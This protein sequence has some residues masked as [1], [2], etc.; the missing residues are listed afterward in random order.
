M[1]N[2]GVEGK[3]RSFLPQNPG[4]ASNPSDHLVSGQLLDQIDA[5][6]PAEENEK[7]EYKKMTESNQSDLLS[8]FYSKNNS[9]VNYK[10]TQ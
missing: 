7:H 4:S 9:N 2:E 1:R 5:L 10:T 3:E 8:N 6:S